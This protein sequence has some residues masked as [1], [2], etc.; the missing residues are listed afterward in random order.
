MPNPVRATMADMIAR[1]RTLIGDT[2]PGSAAQLPP[3][4]TPAPTT[5]A[6][7]GTVLAGVYQ[8]I[9]S[10]VNVN[11]ESLGSAAG[12]VTTTGST[13]TFTIP[14]PIPSGTAT[15]WYAY[16]TQ[17]NGATFTRQQTFGTPTAIGT[18]LLLT[19]PPT[20][21]GA[22]PPT[23]NTSGTT[24]FPDQA[25]QD[26]LDDTKTEVQFVE[27]IP[28]FTLNA[29]T[30]V[31]TEYYTPDDLGGQ[32]E[33][34]ETLWNVSFQQ[35]TPTNSD[36]VVGH[37]TFSAGQLPP[38]IIYGSV[39]D[40][41]RAAANLLEMWAA[42]LT[43]TQFDFTSDGQS[44]RLSQ[45]ITGKQALARQYRSRAHPRTVKVVR[46]DA[47]ATSFAARVAQ[48]GPVSAGVPFLTGP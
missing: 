2:V 23:S 8:V 3:P 42:Q 13:S 36:R 40:I 26:W 28:R 47:M 45:I 16:V 44:F 9:V 14:S 20:N 7:G 11:G 37:W 21:T 38:V 46:S 27:L 41:W 12:S 10:Y 25:V 33:T 48:Y 43:S 6:S 39:F 18:S 34:N 32:W 4:A 19:A 15:G 22:N 30:Y 24:F 1:V 5:A 29:G 31:W 17:A 35:L